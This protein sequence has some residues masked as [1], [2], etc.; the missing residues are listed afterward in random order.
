MNK[1]WMNFGPRVGLAYDPKGDGR[2]SIRASY[3][4]TYDFVVGSFHNNTSIAPPW[5]AQIRIQ[6]PGGGLDD[7]FRDFPGGNPFPFV[8]D[9]NARFTPYGPFL[10]TPYDIKTTYVQ[11]WNLSVQ[12]QVGADWL[13]SGSYIGNGTTHLWVTRALNVPIFFP[14]APVNGVCTAQGLTLAA[15][16]TSCSTTANLDQRRRLSFENPA[17]GQYIGFLDEYDDGGTQSYNGLLLNVQRRA[18][19]GVTVG[20][21]YT[22]SHCIGNAGVGG[23]SPGTGAKYHNVNDRD[24]DRANCAGDRRHVLNFTSVAEVPRFANPTL[25]AV[26]SGWR[27]S[28]IY[29]RQTGQYLTVTTGVDRALTGFVNQ[30]PNQILENPY[31]DGS[32][33]NYLNPAAFAQPAL[34]SISGVGRNNILGPA[35]WQFDVALSRIFQTRESQRLELRAEAF[36]VTNSLRRGNPGLNFNNSTFGQITTALDARV[37]QFAVKYLF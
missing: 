27:L 15:T 5:G 10:G 14:G 37:M 33:R 20:T 32:L 34:G 23:G 25:A 7:P 8:F 19:R 18:A 28:A 6:A 24:V 31:G 9:K 29:R 21:N 2:T 36:N 16:G 4:I 35:F 22:W 12:R 13:F 3:G 17:E 11:S 26:A 1:G 30:R